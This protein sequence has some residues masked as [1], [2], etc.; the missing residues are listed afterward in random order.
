MDLLLEQ[1]GEVSMIFF[2]MAEEDVRE[3]LG[4]DRS[5]VASDGLHFQAEKPHPRSYGGVE[6]LPQ[7]GAA[8]PRLASVRP[9]VSGYQRIIQP[10]SISM[11][12]PVMKEDASEA[13]KAMRLPISS[14]VPRRLMDCCSST[15]Q[16]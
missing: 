2:H 7:P 14:G 15:Q 1:N 5:L 12:W 3:V 9:E 6:T 4:W 13:R 11:V 8:H 10:P 16:L